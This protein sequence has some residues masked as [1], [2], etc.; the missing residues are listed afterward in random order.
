M[1]VPSFSVNMERLKHGSVVTSF[2][3]KQ[4]CFSKLEGFFVRMVELLTIATEG[5][6]FLIEKKKKRVYSF[7]I[8]KHPLLKP[9]K[10]GVMPL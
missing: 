9:E 2:V 5:I 4:V 1:V 6:L 10:Q 3:N 7:K 8:V